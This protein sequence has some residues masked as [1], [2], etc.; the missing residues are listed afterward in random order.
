MASPW[1]LTASTMTGRQH[2]GRKPRPLCPLL[3]YN[4]Y[5]NI[6]KIITGQF[7]TTQGSLKL[8]STIIYYMMIFSNTYLACFKCVTIQP[9]VSHNATDLL[10]FNCKWV[11]WQQETKQH[12]VCRWAKWK[13]SDT[14]DYRFLQYE[15]YRYKRQVQYTCPQFNAPAHA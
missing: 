12:W 5:K 2:C 11:A 15:Y 1:S 4:Y 10:L 8:C 3:Q 9:R 6:F 7:T 14:W 13:V